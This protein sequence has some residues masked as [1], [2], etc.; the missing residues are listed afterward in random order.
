MRRRRLR[1]YYAPLSQQPPPPPVGIGR[2]ILGYFRTGKPITAPIAPIQTE[3]R[4]PA[5]TKKFVRT[6]VFTLVGGI[7]LGVVAYQTLK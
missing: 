3:V 6:M 2:Q 1:I 7:I 5:E 4:I